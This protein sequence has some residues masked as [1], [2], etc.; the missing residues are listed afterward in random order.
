M[1]SLRI[2]ASATTPV[3]VCEYY[4]TLKYKFSYG[5]CFNDSGSCGNTP[6]QCDVCPADTYYWRYCMAA[7]Y[8]QRHPEV[9]VPEKYIRG[10]KEEAAMR[11]LFKKAKNPN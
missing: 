8:R 3:V 6:M 5:P 4:P 9:P 1:A 2:T 7:H 11:K 10:P